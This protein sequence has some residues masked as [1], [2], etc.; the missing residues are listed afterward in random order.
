MTGS[1]VVRSLPEGLPAKLDGAFLGK[2]PAK[3]TDISPGSHEVS[4]ADGDLALE[5]KVEVV[6]GTEKTITLDLEAERKRQR[7]VASRTALEKIEW[8]QRPVPSYRRDDAISVL[9]SFLREH[10]HGKNTPWVSERLSALVREKQLALEKKTWDEWSVQFERAR[11]SEE[12]L[13]LCEQFLER[14]SSHPK[15]AN[16]RDQHAKAKAEVEAAKLPFC[17]KCKKIGRTKDTKF[18]P[19]CGLPLS[20]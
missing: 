16:V 7:E 8:T 19:K 6:A 17:P 15:A 9:E 14:W 12:K 3:K 11:T 13:A 1:L 5:E 4:V 20:R 10:S 18:C 2:T